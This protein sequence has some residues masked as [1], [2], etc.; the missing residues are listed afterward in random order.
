MNNLIQILSETVGFPTIISAVIV[1]LIML[2]VK[3]IKPNISPKTEL[4]IRLLVSVL[5]RFGVIFITKGE[6][7]TLAESSLSVCGVSL[8]ICAFFNK[9]G[10]NQEI[11][12]LV[13]SF[14]PNVEKQTIDQIFSTMPESRE[15]DFEKEIESANLAIGVKQITDK[16]QSTNRL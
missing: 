8:I 3:K 13:S 11:K 1:C 5:V 10:S 16:S 2:L 6:I 14:L 7:Y 12:E 4:I 9:G 15:D